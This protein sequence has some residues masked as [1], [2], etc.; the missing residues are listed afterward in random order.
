[1][2][3]ICMPNVVLFYLSFDSC[4][5]HFCYVIRIGVLF[6]KFNI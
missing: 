1:M 2:R 5:F 4:L 3:V 6:G